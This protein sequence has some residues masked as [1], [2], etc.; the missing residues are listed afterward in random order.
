MGPA[1]MRPQLEAG[2]RELGLT[3]GETQMQ[4]LLDYLTLIQKWNKV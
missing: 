1:S 2:A 4:Q 3:L